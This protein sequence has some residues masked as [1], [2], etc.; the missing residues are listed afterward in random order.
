[1]FYFED[2]TPPIEAEDKEHRRDKL[3][4]DAEHRD[5]DLPK[6]E[7]ISPEEML[8]RIRKLM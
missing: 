1:M 4:S 5:Q 6:P 7:E 3:Q 8:E 2:S